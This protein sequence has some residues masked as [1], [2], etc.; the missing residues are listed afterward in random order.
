MR[1]LET[2]CS[3]EILIHIYRPMIP[4]TIFVAMMLTLSQIREFILALSIPQLY[5]AVIAVACLVWLSCAY[6]S[7]LVARCL[8]KGKYVIWPGFLSL[9]SEP[10]RQRGYAIGRVCLWWIDIDTT[11]QGLFVAVL[12]ATNILVLVLRADS[13]HTI[14]RR[15]GQ[16]AV[17]HL[18]PLCFGMHF[19]LPAEIFRI[20]RS[21]FACFHRWTGFLSIVHSILHAS[22]ILEAPSTMKMTQPSQVVAITVSDCPENTLESCC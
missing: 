9:V 12:L 2:C 20:E 14:M 3:L 5:G 19:G 15:A 1:L 8:W 22:F 13:W 6:G 21:T 16:L 18:V 11:A 17:L 7:L 4:P 10:W